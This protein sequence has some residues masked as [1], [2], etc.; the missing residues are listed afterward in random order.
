MVLPFFLVFF[1]FLFFSSSSSLSSKSS[2][3]F[4]KTTERKFEVFQ[5]QVARGSQRRAS[6]WQGAKGRVRPKIL[7]GI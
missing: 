7:R 6:G 4:L 1:C 2:C 3:A 5:A